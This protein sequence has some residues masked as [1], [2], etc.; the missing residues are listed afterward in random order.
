MD[1]KGGCRAQGVRWL[2]IVVVSEL[3]MDCYLKT[4]RGLD[5]DSWTGRRANVGHNIGREAEEWR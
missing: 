2:E 4:M 5:M 1:C 3:S